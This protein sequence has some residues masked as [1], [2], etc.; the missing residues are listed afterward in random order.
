[1]KWIKKVAA[2]PLFEVAK[3]IDSLQ[4]QANDRTNAPSIHS[5]NE[6]LNNLN[7]N[8]SNDI[9]EV[10]NTLTEYIQAAGRILHPVGSIYISVNDTNPATLFGGTWERIQDRFLLAAGQTYTAGATGGEASHTLT[11]AEMPSHTPLQSYMGG[12]VQSVDTT[13]AGSTMGIY[14][15]LVDDETTATGEGQAHN[16]MPPY[17]AVYVWKRVS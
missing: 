6:A 11:N 13:G 9:T 15:G 17:L 7:D 4:P 2:T 1:M 3:I 14:T 5:V 8:L 12:L 10:N 16:N